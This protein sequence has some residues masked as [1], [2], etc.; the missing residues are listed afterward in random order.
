MAKV[1][2]DAVCVKY[3]NWV[4]TIKV[5]M[6][7]CMYGMKCKDDSNDLTHLKDLMSMQEQLTGMNGRLTNDDFITVILGMLPSHTDY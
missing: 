3:E 4:L 2:W 7:C 1:V 5:D 6:R